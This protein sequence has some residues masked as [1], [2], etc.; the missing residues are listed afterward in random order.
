MVFVEPT[1]SAVRQFHIPSCFDL[2]H[3][4]AQGVRYQFLQT[5]MGLEELLGVARQFG[6]GVLRLAFVVG[7]NIAVRLEIEQYS[8]YSGVRNI[9]SLGNLV[10]G[11]QRH[12]EVLELAISA[13]D[14]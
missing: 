6:K 13:E 10:H 14:H 2:L 8:A 5:L 1:Q 9:R 3:S 7:Q 4:L 12:A 11:L